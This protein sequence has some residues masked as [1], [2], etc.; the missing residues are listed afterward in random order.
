MTTMVIF[1]QEMRFIGGR[2]N[3]YQQKKLIPQEMLLQYMFVLCWS[4]TVYFGHHS[5]VEQVQRRFTKRLHGLRDLS[6][7]ERLEL[8]NLQSL[9]VQRLHFD[10]I[11]CSRIV[12][13]LV[14]V[15]KYDFFQLNHAS[16][17]GHPYKLY[18]PFSHCRTRT[19]FFSIR[20]VNVRNDLPAD[21]VD[22]RSLQSFKTSSTAMA[23]RPRELGDFK[24]A[25]VNGGTNNHPLKDSHKCLSRC[26]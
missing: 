7:T 18:K 4:T 2:L 1:I 16:T 22:F 3:R 13:G 21:I 25:R 10:L 5:A 11:L 8:L 14:S 19:S 20:V 24:K 17:R 12:F 26:R 6:Y 9:E 23:E 15:K